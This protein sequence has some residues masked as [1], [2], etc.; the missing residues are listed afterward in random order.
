MKTVIEKGGFIKMNKIVDALNT[1]NKEY[2]E[3]IKY[4]L[5]KILNLGRNLHNMRL[6]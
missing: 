5:N 3:I 2:P 4:I 1:L 6:K